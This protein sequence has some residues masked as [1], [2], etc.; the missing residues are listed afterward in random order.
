MPELLLVAINI[1]CNSNVLHTGKLLTEGLA[2]R[3]L[4][5]KVWVPDLAGSMC[6][7]LRQDPL[8]SQCFSLSRSYEMQEG[9]LQ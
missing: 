1:M 2:H 3:T 5:Q 9:N 4:T 7:D 6:C 8:P